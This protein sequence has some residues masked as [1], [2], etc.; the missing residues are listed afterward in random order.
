[1]F[2]ICIL[3]PP[4]VRWAIQYITFTNV[5]MFDL[6]FVIIL[7]VNFAEKCFSIMCIYL[8]NSKHVLLNNLLLK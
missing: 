4:G 8:L 3:V 7:A 6:I 5:Y 2:F 1:M